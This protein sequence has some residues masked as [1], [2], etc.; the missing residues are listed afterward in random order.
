MSNFPRKPESKSE[1]SRLSEL[2]TPSQ[3]TFLGEQTGPAEDELEKR[4]RELYVQRP[5]VWRRA[6]LARVSYGEPSVCSVVL[7]IRLGEF[8]EESIQK[9]YGHKFSDIRRSGDFYDQ[10]FIREEQELELR[11]VCAPFYEAV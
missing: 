11:K 3:V 6:Y 8:V 2:I 9:Q 5:E 4:L 1:P 10:M 7:C